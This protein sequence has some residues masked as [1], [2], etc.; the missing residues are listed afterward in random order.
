MNV[1]ERDDPA[2]QVAV[3]GRAMDLEDLRNRPQMGGDVGAPRPW[4][5]CNVT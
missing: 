5:I 2:Q 3:A 1:A 4:A